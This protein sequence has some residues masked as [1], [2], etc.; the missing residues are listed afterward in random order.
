[1]YTFVYEK[2]KNKNKH[3]FIAT[4]KLRTFPIFTTA[5]LKYECI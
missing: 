1:M 5:Y 4:V 3:F 2:K